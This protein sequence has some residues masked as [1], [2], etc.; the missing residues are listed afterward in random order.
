MLEYLHKH[1]LPINYPTRS[2]KTNTASVHSNGLILC[3]FSYATGEP[4]VYTE[5]KWMLRKEIVVGLG[6]WFALLHKLSRQFVKEFPVLASHA[7]H[8]TTLHD[9]VLA[10]VPVDERD[11]LTVT[12]P[13]YFGIIHGDVNPSNY[14]WDAS[15][16]MPC[17]FDWDQLQQSWFL[18]DLSTPIWGVVTLEKAG[19]PI[20]RTAVP[21]ANSKQ[22]TD[23]LVEGYEANG[24]L[25]VDR[26][27]LHRMVMIRR[28]LYVRFCRKAVLELAPD[29]PIFDFCKFMADFFDKEE[30]C[31]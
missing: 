17:M 28:Q 16:G 21:E 6:H 26:E 25:K 20:D 1:N 29:H 30:N 23:W 11:Q 10:G 12:D 2:S 14:F 18:Y 9:G 22:Y 15:V 24:G 4:V 3:L 5:W 27:A 8:W 13:Q 31:P 19:S 7:R